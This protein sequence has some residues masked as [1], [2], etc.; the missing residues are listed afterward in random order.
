MQGVTLIFFKVSMIFAKKIEM[1]QKGDIFFHSIRHL[2]CQHAIK[3]QMLLDEKSLTL[4]Q[5]IGGV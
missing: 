2:I 3:F 4:I 5:D 1:H